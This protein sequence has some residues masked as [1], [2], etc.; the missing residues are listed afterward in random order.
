[1]VTSADIQLSVDALAKHYGQSVLIEDAAQRPVWW[2]TVGAV[3]PV[4]EKTIL[5][6]VVDEPTAFVVDEFHLRDSLVPVRTPANEAIEMWAR[7]CMPIRRDSEL[8]GFLWLLDPEEKITVHN[9]A[10]LVECAKLAANAFGELHQLNVQQL[11]RDELLSKL[12]RGTDPRA[13]SELI[14]LEGLPD[15]SVVQVCIPADSRGWIVGNRF[16]VHINSEGHFAAT[17]GAAISLVNLSEAVKRAQLTVQA[18]RAGAKLSRESWDALGAWRFIVEAPDSLEP[19]DIHPGA[20]ELL[21]AARPELLDTARVVLD[22]GGDINLS[23]QIMYLHRTTL[24]YRIERIAE[25]IGVDLRS[26]PKRTDLQLALWL[27]A[28]RAQEAG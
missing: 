16:S 25:L 28:F 6:R 4:R 19:S 23:S 20:K 14:A 24:Y 18:I 8:L 9:L 2:S 7:W 27:A 21:D 1:M 10:P 22:N 12:L 5:Y 3:D 26:D 13:A 15:K 11:T 17:S